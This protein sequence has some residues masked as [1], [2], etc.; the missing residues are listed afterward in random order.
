MPV[1]SL[2]EQGK[3]REYM[4]SKNYLYY[5]VNCNIY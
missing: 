3:R 5:I 1:F 2:Q 4:I